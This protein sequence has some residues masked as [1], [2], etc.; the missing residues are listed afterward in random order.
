MFTHRTPSVIRIMRKFRFA[1]YGV[2]R[3]GISNIALNYFGWWS[4]SH[5]SGW[6]FTQKHRHMHFVHMGW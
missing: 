3:V 2:S 1:G 6:F 4:A 5:R